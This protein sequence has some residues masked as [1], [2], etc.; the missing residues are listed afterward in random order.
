MYGRCEFAGI[1]SVIAVRRCIGKRVGLGYE[2]M[3]YGISKDP[4]GRRRHHHNV[5]MN[6]M[7][8]SCGP[9]EKGT[10]ECGIYTH[11]TPE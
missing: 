5:V 2:F 9:S 8:I 6:I 4:F 11:E 10:S 7:L 3:S 1:F